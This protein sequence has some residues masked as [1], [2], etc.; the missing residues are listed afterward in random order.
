MRRRLVAESVKTGKVRG[1][2]AVDHVQ[3]HAQLQVAEGT[4]TNR[5][6]EVPYPGWVV[7]RGPVWCGVEERWSTS[8]ARYEL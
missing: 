4:R 6:S 1:E 7:M 5:R 2:V 8:N 3:K